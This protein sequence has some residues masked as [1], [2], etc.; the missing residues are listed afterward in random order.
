MVDHSNDAELQTSHEAIA[1]EPAEEEGSQNR[2]AGYERERI[3]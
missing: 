2:R 3:R 1:S